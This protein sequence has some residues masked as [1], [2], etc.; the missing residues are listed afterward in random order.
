M[1][2]II[3]NNN[4]NGQYIQSYKKQNQ[5]CWHS[6]APQQRSQSCGAAHTTTASIVPGSW[7]MFDNPV[8]SPD[9]APSDYHLFQHLKMFLIRQHFLND[10]DM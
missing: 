4:S 10:D 7:E 8:Y 1:I 5:S 2:S 6:V 9:L 3:T